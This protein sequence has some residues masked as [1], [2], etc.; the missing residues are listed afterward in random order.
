MITIHN[1]SQ[2]SSFSQELQTLAKINKALGHPA[3]LAIIKYLAETPHCIT[4]DISNHLP[5]SRSTVAQHLKELK[6]TGL[7]K[8]TIDGLKVNYCLNIKEIKLH[9]KYTDI[10]F[11]NKLQEKACSNN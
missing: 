7:I 4:G 3:R 2:N 9:L 5:L 1:M 11:S 8:G 6:T 10:F